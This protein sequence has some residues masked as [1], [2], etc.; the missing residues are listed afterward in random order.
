MLAKYYRLHILNSTGQTLTYDDG[1]RLSVALMPWKFTS[2]ILDYGTQIDDAAAFLTTAGT[3]ATAVS[4]EG[5][6]ID[7]SSNLYL[8]VKGYFS[9][10][11][12]L[13]ATDGPLYLYL[14][15]STNNSDWPSDQAEFTIAEDLRLVCVLTMEP[16]A[17]D[18]SR[19]TNFEF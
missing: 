15:E 2:G 17:V 11:A 19:G 1:A 7:N 4:T 16:D 9:A 14:E 18:E 12:D 6:V 8:G 3:L 10:I 5:T 13:A